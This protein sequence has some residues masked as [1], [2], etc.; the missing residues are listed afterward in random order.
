MFNAIKQANGTWSAMPD[1]NAANYGN[2]SA[3]DFTSPFSAPPRL[4]AANL[5]DQLHPATADVERTFSL[6]SRSAN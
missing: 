3:S 1:V 6:S 5:A 2:H 4:H